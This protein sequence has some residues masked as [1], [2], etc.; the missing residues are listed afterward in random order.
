MTGSLKRALFALILAM[1]SLAAHALTNDDLAPLAGDDFEAKTAAID[2]LIAN[3]DA[4]SIAVLGALSD[5]SLV[6]TDNGPSTFRPMTARR[7]RSPARPPKRPM[8]SRSR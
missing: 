2:K 5:G 6:A 3:A 7:T 4:P 1:T 8:R